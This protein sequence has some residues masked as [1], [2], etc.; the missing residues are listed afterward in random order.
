[1]AFWHEDPLRSVDAGSGYIHTVTVTRTAANVLHDIEET[2]KLMR[3]N[4]HVGYDNSGYIG[5]EKW[6]GPGQTII[7]VKS[8]SAP[9]YARPAFNLLMRMKAST[10][11]KKLRRASLPRAAR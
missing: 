4:D 7:F 6:E 8:S 9:T 1:M 10:G 2:H 11:I 3:E 5:V